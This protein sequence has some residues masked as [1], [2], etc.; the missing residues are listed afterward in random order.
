MTADGPDPRDWLAA[1]IDGSDDAII[2]KNLRGIIQ[3]WNPAATRLFG[4]EAEEVIGKSITILIPED[5]LDEEPAILAEIQRGMRVEHFETV[6]RRKDGSFIDISLTISPIRNAQGMIVG[7]SKIARDITERRRTQAEQE[8]LMGEMRHRVKNLFALAT[9]IVSISG[10][11]TTTQEDLLAT[12]QARLSSLARAHQL[13]GRD[14]FSL[15]LRGPIAQ[16]LHVS[17][18][19]PI[20]GP[21]RGHRARRPNA[22]PIL[23]Y[24]PSFLAAATAVCQRVA[25]LICQYVS[26]AV[27]VSKQTLQRLAQHFSFRPAQDA[28]RAFVPARHLALEVGRNDRRID[29]AMDD[30]SPFR[31]RNRFRTAGRSGIVHRAPPTRWQRVSVSPQNRSRVNVESPL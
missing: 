16:D 22:A 30:L 18:L 29:R 19:H 15:A 11:S 7:A 20:G 31:R 5:R 25:H 28:V 3:S 12:I 13:F 9:A 8:L 1:I 10:R 4:Y 24:T 23:A 6:R 21:D 27:L 2:S 14:L 17:A 26:L